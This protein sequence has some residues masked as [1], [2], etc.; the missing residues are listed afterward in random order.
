MEKKVGGS[1]KKPNTSDKIEA[2]TQ[3]KYIMGIHF[4]N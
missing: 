4:M 2:R 3:A 1:K